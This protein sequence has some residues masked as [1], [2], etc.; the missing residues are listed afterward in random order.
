MLYHL[1]GAF[2]IEDFTGMSE[3]HDPIAEHKKK[4]PARIRK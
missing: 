3:T 4:Y 1:F 2:N